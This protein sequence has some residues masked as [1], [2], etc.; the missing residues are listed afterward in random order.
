M[1]PE[2]PAAPTHSPAP[3]DLDPAR[4]RSLQAAA[5]WTLAGLG[6]GLMPTLSHAEDT[7]TPAWTLLR[8]NLF[9][10]RPLLDGSAVL[11]IDAPQRA[12]DGS[13]VPVSI[14]TQRSELAARVRRIHLVIDENPSP[15]AGVFEF[16]P[17]HAPVGIET[18]VRVETYTWMRAVAETD[19]QR[20]YLSSIYVKASGGCS[21]PANK[22]FGVAE[23]DIGRMRLRVPE[24]IAP[25]ESVVAQLMVQHPNNSGLVMEQL[26]RTFAPAYYLHRIEVDYAGQPIWRGEVN[27]SISQ[28]PHFRFRFTP[29]ASG[30]LVARA[31]DVRGGHWE[32]SL[33]LDLRTAAAD[34]ANG[35]TA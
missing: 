12:A 11:S 14:W 7:D 8:A 27:F 26:A 1:N 34:P 21:T 6:A 23:A 15:V 4:R 35:R 24:E 18:R 33:A 20:L 22:D 2:L 3:C 19:D 30:L 9:G 10:D 25:G 32:S 29:R 13:V 5:A 28:N 17:G 16:A 31:D